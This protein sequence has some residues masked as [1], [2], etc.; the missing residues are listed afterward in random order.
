[1]V[2]RLVAVGSFSIPL[3]GTLEAAAVTGL[4]RRQALH[5]ARV[6]GASR[7]RLVRMACAEVVL[8]ASLAVAVATTVG[9]GLVGLSRL[10][11]VS[12]RRAFAGSITV[13]GG[14]E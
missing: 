7:G 9:V 10:G 8:V 11:D 12:P 14:G 5:V 6:L 2:L 13:P 1:M 3:F 4:R